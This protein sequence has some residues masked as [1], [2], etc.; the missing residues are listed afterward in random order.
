MEFSKRDK[1]YLIT[2]GYYI[3]T[4]K[5]ILKVDNIENKE[6]NFIVIESY[7]VIYQTVTGKW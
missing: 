2:V 1:A 7:Q 6:L 3:K 5:D 4:Y